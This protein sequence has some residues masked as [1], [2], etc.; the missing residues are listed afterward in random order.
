MTASWQTIPILQYFLHCEI[1][2][3][4]ITFSFRHHAQQWKNLQRWNCSDAT[5]AKNSWVHF[6]VKECDAAVADGHMLHVYQ[7]VNVCRAM[8]TVPGFNQTQPAE[9]VCAKMCWVSVWL[10][11][12]RLFYLEQWVTHLSIHIYFHLGVEMWWKK[13]A[14]SFFF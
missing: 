12:L 1:S 13:W 11:I 3:S 8:F 4:Y 9:L 5:S 14:K 7:N 6:A 10:H 2:S